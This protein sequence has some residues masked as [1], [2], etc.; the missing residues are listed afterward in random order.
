MDH[1]DPHKGVSAHLVPLS[2]QGYPL[3]DITQQEGNSEMSPAD[4]LV[5]G[6]LEHWLIQRQISVRHR[7]LVKVIIGVPLGIGWF[8][9]QQR[10]EV[11]SEWLRM[12]IP[13]FPG[14]L[15]LIGLVEL[16]SGIPI[17]RI[18]KAWDSLRGWQRGVIGTLILIA[19]AA[20][21]FAGMFLFLV[22]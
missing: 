20:L 12:A 22:P 1:Q 10:I 19:F 13:G 16:T 2:G 15:A 18:S 21:L 5:H 6:R 7:G 3:G 17:S 11:M 9:F 4:R 14:V 8:L